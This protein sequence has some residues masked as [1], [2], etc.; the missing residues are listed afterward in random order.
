[1]YKAGWNTCEQSD[2]ESPPQFSRFWATPF[3]IFE[4][5]SLGIDLIML[6]LEFRTGPK[7]AASN[8]RIVALTGESLVHQGS[9]RAPI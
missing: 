7:L 5:D 6:I 4:N 3:T 8:N 2:E 1:M 9:S